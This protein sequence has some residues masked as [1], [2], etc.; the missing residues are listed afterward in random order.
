MA[1]GQISESGPYQAWVAR[2]QSWSRDPSTSLDGLP[3]LDDA[4]FD[5]DTYL[6]LEEHWNVAIRGFMGRWHDELIRSVARASDNHQIASELVR[7]RHLLEPR[8]RL[9]THPG[10]PAAIRDALTKALET[11]LRSI[12]NEIESALARSTDSGRFDVGKNDQLVEIARQNSLL[13]LL[14]PSAPIPVVDYSAPQPASTPDQSA[15][16]QR[17]VRR[18]I[19]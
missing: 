6:R 3:S 12:Q 15:P 14:G 19:F 4:T 8:L 10:W 7:M 2:L 18:I 5:R 13:S 17:S 16:S 1:F 9:A 11:D